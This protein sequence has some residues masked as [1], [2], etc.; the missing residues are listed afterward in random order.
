MSNG[1]R[2]FPSPWPSPHPMGRG[3]SFVRFAKAVRGAQI[4]F[5]LAPSDGERAGVRGTAIVE[6]NRSDKFFTMCDRL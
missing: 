6:L 3:N 4:G 1:A 5:T 2:R